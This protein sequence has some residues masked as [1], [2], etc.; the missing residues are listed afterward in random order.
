[1][2]H[3]LCQIHTVVVMVSHEIFS[4]QVSKTICHAH[5]VLVQRVCPLLCQVHTVVVL[6]S[7]ECGRSRGWIVRSKV[8]GAIASIVL[9][10][11]SK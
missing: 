5:L 3:L 8:K 1:M 7:H 9:V 10:S 2:Y 11:Y 4:N 6:V